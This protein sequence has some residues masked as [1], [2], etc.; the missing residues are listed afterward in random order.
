M[1]VSSSVIGAGGGTTVGVRVDVAI[2]PRLSSMMYGRGVAVPKYGASGVN[3]TVPFAC[4]T[5][6][7]WPATATVVCVQA[8]AVSDAPHNST[9]LGSNG[10]AIAPGE[11][12]PIGDSVCV[13]SITP[14]DV[15][16]RAVGFGM[17]DGVNVLVTVTFNESVIL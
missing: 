15:S 17:I 8:G 16:G 13:F 14:I 6:V 4:T 11:S 2:C 5:Y 10:Y 3:F 1:P 12:L 7:P 9:V